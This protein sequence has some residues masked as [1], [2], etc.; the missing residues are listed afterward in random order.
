[1]IRVRGPFTTRS[2]VGGWKV[3]DT[4]PGSFYNE[5]ESGRLEGE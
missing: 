3:N 4:C 5:I 1:M 2:K